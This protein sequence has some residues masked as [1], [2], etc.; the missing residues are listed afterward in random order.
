MFLFA[1]MEM[2]VFLARDGGV[3]CDRLG[4]GLGFPDPI[5]LE[6]AGMTRLGWA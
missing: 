5:P 3:D 2:L 4:F 6:L 1:A